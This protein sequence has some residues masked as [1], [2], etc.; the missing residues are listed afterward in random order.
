MSYYAIGIGG[1]GAK[2]LESLVHLAA[3]GIMPTDRNLHVLFVDP[4]AANGSRVRAQQTLGHYRRCKNALKLGQTPL[5]KTKIDSIDSDSSLYWSPFTD[6]NPS[7]GNFFGYANLHG[8][9]DKTRA[10]AAHLFEV[11]YSPAERRTPLAKGFHGHPSIGSAVMAQTVNF[12]QEDTWS[13]FRAQIAND[14]NPK[15]FLAGSIFGGT[16]ASGFPTI[17]K[18]VRDEFK[19][20]KLGGALV[21][22]YFKFISEEDGNDETSEED[23]K[24]KRD[25]LK[26][27]SEYF[28]MNTQAAL[29]YY[30]Q[31][32]QTD[33]YNAVY[34][35]GNESQ[36]EVANF[37]GGPEQ[38]NAPHFIEL[39]A[40][41][42]AIDFFKKGNFKDG[43]AAQYFLTAREEKN[44]LQWRD[45]PDGANGNTIRSQIGQLARFAFAYLHVYQPKLQEIRK[46]R[47]RGSKDASWFR[48]FFK[49]GLFKSSQ[50]DKI[51]LETSETQDALTYIEIYCQAFLRWLA[52]IQTNCGENEKI[53]LIQHGAFFND[54]PPGEQ[55]L[56][57]VSNFESGRFSDLIKQHE[58]AD[59]DTL[60]EQ[61]CEGKG[62]AN[63]A[64]GIGKFLR[65]L[66]QNC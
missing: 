19:D 3:A 16:G 56:K 47:G 1:T 17:A 31:L 28:L 61:M 26:A 22:P 8:A 38:E 33:T 15:I 2:F 20:V 30:Y 54:G 59:L 50:R 14:N 23:S 66:Y 11:L 10:A 37:S 64:E 12:N 42:A 63:D 62:K 49:S 5:L 4:D 25:E 18:L 7:L 36:T 29:Q 51:D 39:Y 34:L 32:D 27:K 41:L 6:A 44:R 52:N 13:T 24:K 21:L 53:D 65:A 46:N 43:E 35:L 48:D 60:W 55:D 58:Y 9:R 57:P 45:L 40:A